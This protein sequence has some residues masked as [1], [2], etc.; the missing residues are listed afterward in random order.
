MQDVA[1]FS[2]LSIHNGGLD[3]KGDLRFLTGCMKLGC[4]ETIESNKADRAQ[5]STHTKAKRLIGYRLMCI[6][7]KG[8]CISILAYEG[9]H[10][11]W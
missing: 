2:S 10:R 4:F 5:A 11:T 9:N 3:I 8:I 7:D 6:E 1:D